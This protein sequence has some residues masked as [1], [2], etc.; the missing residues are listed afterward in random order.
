L[1]DFGSNTNLIALWNS[2]FARKEDLMKRIDFEAHF[3]TREHL[4]ALAENEGYPRLVEG[5]GERGRRLWHTPDVGQPYGDPL[6][7]AL[8]D[9]GEERLTKM[10]ACGIDI[11]VLSVSAPS[12]DQ[13]D[14]VVGK[15]LAREANNMLSKVIQKHPDRFMGY[16]VLAPKAPEEAADELER[17]VKDLG[18]IGWNTHSNYAGSYLDEEKYLPILERAERLGVPI[19]LHPTVPAIPQV[20]TYGFAIAG[21]PFG[22]G[23]ETAMCMMRLI[24]SEVFDKYPGLKFILGHL[25]EALPFLMKRIDW[26]YVRPFDPAARPSISKKPS[27]YLQNNVFVTTSGNYYEPAFMC[28]RE[29]MGIDRILLGTDYPYED[30]KECIQFIEGLSIPQ[31][32]KDR[33]YSGN[34][35]QLGLH[36]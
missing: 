30:P 19:Y 26:A 15:P 12:I 28:T 23:M 36:G 3:F 33:I 29:A 5:D 14:P 7:N 24:Y 16:A 25:G 17:A 34:A 18:F 13:L 8:T 4:K 1:H 20:R 6:I 35:V 10:D 21:A 9:L 32:E 27:E 22:F 11:Q 31:E 2:A